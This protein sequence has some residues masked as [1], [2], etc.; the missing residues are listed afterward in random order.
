[1][2]GYSRLSFRL[3][4]AMRPQTIFRDEPLDLH[5]PLASHHMPSLSFVKLVR[6]IQILPIM[7]AVFV[8]IML[9]PSDDDKFVFL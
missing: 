6:A 1:M 4:R 2:L 8:L 3:S 9:S 7:S 5:T